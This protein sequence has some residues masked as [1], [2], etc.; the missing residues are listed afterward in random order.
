MDAWYWL[1][2]MLSPGIR[3]SRRLVIRDGM[4]DGLTRRRFLGVSAA[5]TAVTTTAITKLPRPARTT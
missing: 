1:G 5:A 2:V 4:L 3:A